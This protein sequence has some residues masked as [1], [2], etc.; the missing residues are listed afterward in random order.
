[1]NGWISSVDQSSG[2]I[3]RT[4][5]NALESDIASG[6]LAAGARLPPLRDLAKQLGISIGTVSKA[7]AYAEKQGLISSEVGRGTFVLDKSLR[8]VHA[9][10]TEDV[11]DFSLN[12]PPQTGEDV[13]VSA[14]LEEIARAA[15]LPSLLQYQPHAGRTDHI[16][17]ISG[18]FEKL[19]LPSDADRLIITPGA[20]HAID[21]AVRLLAKPGDAILTESMTYS[22]IRA[23]AALE[24]YKLVGVAMDEVGIIPEDL[25]AAIAASGARL[26]YS[27]PTL[28]TPTASTMTIERRKQIAEILQ[29][30]DVFL[31]EDDAY[32]FLAEKTVQTLSSMI[33]ERAFYV[34]SFAK[35]L[36][37]GLRVGT[38]IM[39]PHLKDRTILAMRCSGWMAAPIMVEC[40]KRMIENG[41]L[42]RQIARKKQQARRR[43]NIAREV[44]REWLA[45]TATA[46]DTAGFHVWLKLPLNRSSLS[47]ATK[48]RE[49]GLILG[50]PD[51]ILPEDAG[52]HGVRLCLGGI[53]DEQVLKRSLQTLRDVLMH[54]DLMSYV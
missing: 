26:L 8:T 29:R 6:K 20:Q 52:T 49:K 43:T 40:V 39:P 11:Q 14:V 51:V 33:P 53:N 10:E 16:A 34:F 23:L 15:M 4:L 48:A 28:Q 19:D 36:M 50:F 32:A 1:M 31:I 42:D 35:C 38:L 17:A 7:Y 37:P 45:P 3:Y 18:W 24:S 27:T 46:T 54:N 5:V 12:V 30:H 47:V 21:I 41:A 2:P 44:L 13:E 25:E 9:Q 22:G